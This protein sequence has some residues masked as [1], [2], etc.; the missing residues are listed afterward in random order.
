MSEE[1]VITVKDMSFSYNG[2]LVLVDVNLRIYNREFLSMVGP[3]GGGKTTLLKL[4]L[5]LFKPTSG[6]VRIY[7]KP[8]ERSLNLIGYMPQYPLYDPQFPVSVMDVALMGR[9]GH[10]GKG[11]YTK[12][13][14]EA[15]MYALEEVDMAAFYKHRFS[16]LSGGQR[17]R[18][19]LSR[20]LVGGPEILLLDEPTANVDLEIENRLYEILKELNK[21]MTII[22]VTHDLGFVSRIVHRVIC[23]KKKVVIHPTSEISGEL[24]QEIY[25]HDIHMVRHDHVSRKEG[26]N[27]GRVFQRPE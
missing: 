5:G 20:A 19:F 3:N 15:V 9:L 18:V 26:H 17:Q 21:R 25:G 4:M 12:T 27:N 24:I 22:M 14:R 23:V 16:S 11:F 2:K 7:G 13:D 6:E 8:P 1:P 10:H